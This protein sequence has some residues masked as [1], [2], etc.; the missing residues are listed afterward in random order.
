MLTIRM[1]D[2]SCQLPNCAEHART[3]YLPQESTSPVDP[4]GL[5]PGNHGWINIAAEERYPYFH[6]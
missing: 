4:V 2:K 6:N 1:Q 3:R 5:A